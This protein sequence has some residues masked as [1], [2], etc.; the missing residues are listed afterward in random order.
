[1]AKFQKILNS[2]KLSK[3]KNLLKIDTKKVRANLPTF[4]AK[5]AF[6]CLKLALI[7]TS[8]VWYFDLECHIWVETFTSDHANEYMLNQL[9]FK[10]SLD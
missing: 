5:T 8:I 6:K 4:D 2:K 7:K 1:M 9:T 10:A 3:K